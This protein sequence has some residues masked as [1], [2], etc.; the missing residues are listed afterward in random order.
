MQLLIWFMNCPQ[1]LDA[2]LNALD[3]G[4]TLAVVVGWNW[5]YD[6]P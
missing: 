6:Q 5:R 3:G 1:L 2:P 4:P